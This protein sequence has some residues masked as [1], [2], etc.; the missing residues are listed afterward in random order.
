[1]PQLDILTYFPQV[2]WFLVLFWGGFFFFTIKILPRFFN[3]FK[4]RTKFAGKVTA[5]KDYFT[6]QNSTMLDSTVGGI[7]QK[8]T[9]FSTLPSRSVAAKP[10]IQGVFGK[11]KELFVYSAQLYKNFV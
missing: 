1:M 11:L 3:V 6:W 7:F 10:L 8:L 4:Y 5:K 9:T 2:T